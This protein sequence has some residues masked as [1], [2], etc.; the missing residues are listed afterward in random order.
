MFLNLS[1][2]RITRLPLLSY[3]LILILLTGCVD[4]N[5][6]PTPVDIVIESM[7]DS[8]P[9]ITLPEDASLEDEKWAGIDLDQKAP[10]LPLYPDEQAKKFLLPE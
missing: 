10:V 2:H 6:N 3:S 5:K 9:K 4:I 1:K 8:L 7:S